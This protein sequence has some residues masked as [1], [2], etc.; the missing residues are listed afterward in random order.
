MKAY[1]FPAICFPCEYL[2]FVGHRQIYGVDHDA[3]SRRVSSSGLG[4]VGPEKS[5]IVDRVVLLLESR[6]KAKI[7]KLDVPIFISGSRQ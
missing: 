2:I 4:C 3:V 5:L 6:G 7:A 1:K